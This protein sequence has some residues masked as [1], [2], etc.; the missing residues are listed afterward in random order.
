MMSKYFYIYTYITCL[1]QGQPIDLHAPIHW[2][3]ILL[4]GDTEDIFESV[5]SKRSH[6]WRVL[7]NIKYM[8]EQT[9][10]S[11][12]EA[13]DH[14]N[15]NKIVERYERIVSIMNNWGNV[16]DKLN[17]YKIW[18]TD[19]Y[20][21]MNFLRYR[22]HQM[23]FLISDISN[24][25]SRLILWCQKCLNP[26]KLNCLIEIFSRVSK[27]LQSPRHRN[28]FTLH[29]QHNAWTMSGKRQAKMK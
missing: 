27:V 28:L 11:C 25:C 23:S 14:N 6:A 17:G 21:D 19:T 29:R 10:Q 13:V 26:K 8:V 5:C 3:A 15:I 4:Q 20:F 12:W 2:P 9:R 24:I 22:R 18:N 1:F 16:G 7:S